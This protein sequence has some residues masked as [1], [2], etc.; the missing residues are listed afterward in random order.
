M[1]ARR[2]DVG[3]RKGWIVRFHIDWG[4]ERNTLYKGVKIIPEHTCFKNL[5]WLG[6]RTKHPL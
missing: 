5:E 2:G 1:S 4:R 3:S 6:K